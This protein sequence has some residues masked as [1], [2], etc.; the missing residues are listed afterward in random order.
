MTGL[1]DGRG[2][3]ES[4][5]ASPPDLI[6]MDIQ[7]PECDGFVL[8]EEIRLAGYTELPVVALTA[9]AMAGD[10]ER[11]LDAGFR[12]YITKPI[13]IAAFPGQV[14]ALIAR[15]PGTDLASGGGQ[16]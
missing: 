11:A 13:D 8:L 2:L 14:E 9:H 4:L 5:A 1:G 3:I 6:L 16:S 15:V 7:L 10:R 12:G